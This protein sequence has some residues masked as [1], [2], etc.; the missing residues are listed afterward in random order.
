MSQRVLVTGATGFIGGRLPHPLAAAGHEVRCLVRNRGATRARALKR[1]GFD[2]HEADALRPPTL[3]GAGRG[4]DVAYYLIHSMGRGG[5]REF[6]PR[7]RSAAIAF[8]RM[9]RDEGIDRVIYLG[10]LGDRPHSQ[11]LRSRHET[12]LLLRAHGPALT[13]FRAG[14]VVGAESESYRTLRYLVQ[15]LP[16]MIAPAWL[17]NPTQPIAIDDTVSYLVGAL[18]VPESTGREIQ[19]G[20]PDV[21]TYGEM[22]DRMAAVLSVPH[23]PRIP[24]PLITP[25]LSSLWIGLVTP[26]DAGVARPLIEGLAVPTVV[27]EPSAMELFDV[28]PVSFDEALRRAV[29][30]DLSLGNL[31][32][33]PVAAA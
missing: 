32:V 23:R 1:E 28:E 18:D 30:E 3:R 4:I 24:V 13:Y 33:R 11:H 15:R 17:G 14:M 7:E 20:G 9:A 16:A 25:W 21:L 6:A 29:S 10:G 26:V 27:T 19:I 22:L 5:P 2:V 31:P 12:A 8:G